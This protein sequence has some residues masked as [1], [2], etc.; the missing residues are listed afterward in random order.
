M[1]LQV[2]PHL[3]QVHNWFDSHLLKLLRQ[4]WQQG[5]HLFQVVT[6][7]NAREKKDLRG[8]H[9]PS[10]QHHLTCCFKPQPF[11]KPLR[12]FFESEN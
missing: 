10:T 2:A 5:T 1:V 3:W 9:T 11:P 7:T 12:V 4:C 6:V 8:A